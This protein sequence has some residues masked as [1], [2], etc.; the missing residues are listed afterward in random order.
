M[1]SC[2]PVHQLTLENGTRNKI[3]V[4]YYPE[5]NSRQLDNKKVETI[6]MQGREMN[7]VTLDSAETMTIGTVVA[8]YTPSADDINLDYLEVLNGND[9]IKLSGKNA[10]LSVIQKVKSLDYRIIIK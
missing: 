8:R 5:L 3:Q 2:D 9:T 4:I 7:K 10:I 1:A 6:R